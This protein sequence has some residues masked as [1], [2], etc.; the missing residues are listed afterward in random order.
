MERP[1]EVVVSELHLAANRLR[2]AGQRLQDGLSSV[3][4]ETRELLGSGWKGDAASAY[5]TAW[6]QWHH[7]AGQVVRGV[8][9]MSDLLRVA[10]D[11]YDRTDEQAAGAVASSFPASGAGD[12]Q[13]SPSGTPAGSPATGATAQPSTGAA[14]GPSGSSDAL[15]SSVGQVGQVGGQVASGLAQAGQTAG[16]MVTQAAQAAAGV[17]QQVGQTIEQAVEKAVETAKDA[18]GPEDHDGAAPGDHS[19]T[20]APVEPPADP[21]TPG[22]EVP[23]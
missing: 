6:D 9:T 10:G 19:P 1:V 4:L 14:S 20:G 12:G 16:A 11:Q 13:G 17:A 18:K 22:R 23:R 8:Q 15:S 3:D 2:E 7:G 5:S 21:Q